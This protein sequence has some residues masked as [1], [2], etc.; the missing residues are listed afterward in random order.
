MYK[1]MKEINRLDSL[2]K[3]CPFCGGKLEYPMQLDLMD[4]V[5]IE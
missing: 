4:T 1:L 5:A 2:L 3:P